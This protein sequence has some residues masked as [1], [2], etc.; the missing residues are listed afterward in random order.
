MNTTKLKSKNSYKYFLN[1][2]EVKPPGYPPRIMRTQ[3]VL[4]YLSTNINEFNKRFRPELSEI[5]LGNHAVGFDRLQ[6]DALINQIE[7]AS[8]DFDSSLNNNMSR[9]KQRPIQTKGGSTWD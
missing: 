6:I 1:N 9:G 7:S 5:K 3:E 8:I 2:P 4:Y